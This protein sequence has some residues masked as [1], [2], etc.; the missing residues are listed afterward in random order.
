MS[1]LRLAL[2]CLRVGTFVFGGGPVLIPLLEQDVVYRYGWLSP[3]EFVDAVA[4]GQMTPGPLLVSATFVGYKVNG[5][6]GAVVATVC[7]FLP[8]FLMTIAAS[9]QL[10]RIKGNPLFRRFLTGIE[11]GVVGLVAAAAVSVGRSAIGDDFPGLLPRLGIGLIALIVLMRWKVD[12]G[13][14]VVSAGLLALAASLLGAD[15]A[16][17]S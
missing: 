8:S 13:L 12:N 7:I 2:S 6:V 11:A 4:L 17:P 10:A 9:H 5:L 1:L 3:R 15:L 16:V 14:V